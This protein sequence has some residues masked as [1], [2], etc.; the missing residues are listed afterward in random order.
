MSALALAGFT[1]PRR[2]GARA[3]GTRQASAAVRRDRADLLREPAPGRG[4]QQRPLSGPARSARVRVC[5]GPATVCASV[6]M[7]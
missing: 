2:R 7:G 1:R 6:P 3:A 5:T 4:R